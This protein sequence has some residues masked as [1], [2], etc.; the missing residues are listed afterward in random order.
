[1]NSAKFLRTPFSHRTPLVAASEN[2]GKTFP[3]KRFIDD[4]C[5]TNDGGKFGRSI[6]D[7]YPKELE[8]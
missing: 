8:L 7:I 6:C 3:T 5:T 1:M 2:Q 4:L